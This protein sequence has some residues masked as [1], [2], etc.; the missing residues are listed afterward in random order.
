MVVLIGV[1]L[2]HFLT[3]YPHHYSLFHPKCHL[4]CLR[5][6]IALVAQSQKGDNRIVLYL[7]DGLGM[8]HVKIP[9]GLCVK[10]SRQSSQQLFSIFILNLPHSWHGNSDWRH[11]IHGKQKLNCLYVIPLLAL[12]STID[13]CFISLC[14]W[15][16][17]LYYIRLIA[18]TP[19]SMSHQKLSCYHLP[20][21]GRAGI[22]LEDA[23]T[24]DGTEV[25]LLVGYPK[26]K[27]EK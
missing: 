2:Y 16:M 4:S 13:Y 23:D 21:R 18:F 25:V 14:L 1:S 19:S 26:W 24:S 5:S 11:S 6:F 8:S 20:T 9:K 15:L 3:S 17:Y 7:T 10:V 22:K 12:I 27:V